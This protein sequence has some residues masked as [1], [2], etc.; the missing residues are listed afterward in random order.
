MQDNWGKDNAKATLLPAYTI[1][2]TNYPMQCVAGHKV[3]I[4][5][6]ASEDAEIAAA[7]GEFIT[8][9]EN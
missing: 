8:R 2:G 5:N 9:D 1:D 3:G 6:G 7:F 4:V